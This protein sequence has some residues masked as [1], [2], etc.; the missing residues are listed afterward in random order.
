M[1]VDA[2]RGTL[3]HRMKFTGISKIAFF[4]DINTHPTP[5]FLHRRVVH[6]RLVLSVMYPRYFSFPS[7]LLYS[8]SRFTINIP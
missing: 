6:H 1:Q 8:H 3:P 7:V 5:V 4:S 2:S